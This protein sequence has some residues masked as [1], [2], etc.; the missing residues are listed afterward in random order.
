MKSTTTARWS[1]LSVIVLAVV[2]GLG[3]PALSVPATTFVDSTTPGYYNDALGTVLDQTNPYAGTYLFPGADLVDGDPLLATA[4]E[5]DLSAAAG[6]LGDW[7]VNPAALNAN[8]H[9]PE[10]VPNTWDLNAE[11]GIVYVI[12]AG[13]AGLESLTVQVGVDNGAFIWFDGSYLLG[14]LSPGY[15]ILGEY[16]VNLSNISP[17]THYLQILLEDHGSQ[18]SFLVEVSGMP[19]T[20]PAPGAMLLGSL[21]AVVVGWFR[22]RRAL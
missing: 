6:I 15:A 1:F 20:I 18:N 8:W 17:G 11:T 4:P 9:G 5:P 19:N 2:A 22:G 3:T 7:L 14:G 13:S 10:V 21:G 12:D 16:T